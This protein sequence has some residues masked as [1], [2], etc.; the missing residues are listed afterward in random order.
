MLFDDVLQLTSVPAAPP[1]K[2]LESG[3]R[4]GIRLYEGVNLQ[5]P[6]VH[7]DLTDAITMFVREKG[8]SSLFALPEDEAANR[9]APQILASLGLIPRVWR[10]SQ[11]TATAEARRRLQAGTMRTTKTTRGH[12]PRCLARNSG[13]ECSSYDSLSEHEQDTDTSNSGNENGHTSKFVFDDDD[14]ENHQLSDIRAIGESEGYKRG[15]GQLLGTLWTAQ[16]S[17][18]IRQ[19]PT[20]NEHDRN[21]EHFIRHQHRLILGLSSRCLQN[22]SQKPFADRFEP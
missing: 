17:R 9:T 12:I 1:V 21:I 20:N 16:D 7:K 4:Y 14:E 2:P 11:H 15:Q 10:W 18:E 8:A 19:N 5:D 6:A 22:A 3:L 13:S